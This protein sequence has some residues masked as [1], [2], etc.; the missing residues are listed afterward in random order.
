M[1]TLRSRRQFLKQLGL[2]AAALPFV[3]NLPSLGFENST[4]RKQR[5]VIV[6]S[7]NGVVPN[8][9]WP[10]EEGKLEAFKE[11]LAPL[12]PFRDRTLTLHGLCDKIRGDGDN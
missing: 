10:D 7:P 3:S 1:N 8:T 4:A 9:F 5:L 2:S 11:S 12:E 6:F